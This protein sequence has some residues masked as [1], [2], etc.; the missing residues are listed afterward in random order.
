MSLMTLLGTVG[1]AAATVAV[2][3]A[4]TEVTAP[5][6]TL[7]TMARWSPYL[8]GAGI[9]VLAWIAFSLSDR[10]IGA[11]TAYARTAA[12]LEEKLRGPGV[13]QRPYW[14]KYAPKVDWQWVFVLCIVAGSF[15]SSALAGTLELRLVPDL[16]LRSIG[17]FGFLRWLTAL[18]GGAVMGFGARW[19]DG[20]TSGHG[21][22]GSLQ[23]IITSW[24]ALLCFFAGG[25]VTAL[26]FYP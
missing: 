15:L 6:R 18:V 14:Q 12:M 23:L 20:C 17:D 4:A 10:T 26:L 22:S 11:S 9:G 13:E 25:A 2:D 19:A 3:P 8:C 16:W 5:D 7:W 1:L 24:V 21:I